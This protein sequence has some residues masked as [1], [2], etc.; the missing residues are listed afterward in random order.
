MSRYSGL[1]DVV[2]GTTVSG[3][4]SQVSGVEQIVGLFINTIPSRVNFSLS[5][6]LG[7]LLSHIHGDNIRREEYSY[8]PLADI[9]KLSELPQGSAMFD[10]YLVFQNYPVE[11]VIE[12]K[13]DDL[14][15]SFEDSQSYEASNYKLMLLAENGKTLQLGFK[16]NANEFSKETISA[17][18]SHLENVICQMA[19]SDLETSVKKLS[20]LSEQEQRVLLSDW[21]AGQTFTGLDT[22]SFIEQFNDQVAKTPNAIAV[23]SGSAQLTY[24]ELNSR[25]NQLAHYL[26]S[27]G[28]EN[29]IPVALCLSRTPQMVI[30]L[31][32]VLKARGAYLPLDPGYPRARIRYLLDDAKVSLVISDSVLSQ[33]LELL[34]ETLVCLDDS[35]FLSLLQQ[36]PTESPEVSIFG[37]DMAYVIYTSGTTGQPKGVMVTHGGLMNYVSHAGRDYLVEV[38]GAW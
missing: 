10:S 28:I 25:A 8:M 5:G 9:Q 30:A 7:E 4:P 13:R 6:T 12:Q 18:L 29:D 31:M 20:L 11:D 27:Q 15:L 22:T 33:E 19:T 38:Q 37:S 26:I 21:G 14:G 1:S 32:G 23:I 34:D 16:Y 3:R 35:E 2:F 17:L 36:Q 24:G